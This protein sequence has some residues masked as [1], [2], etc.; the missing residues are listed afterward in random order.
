MSIR[1]GQTWYNKDLCLVFYCHA[2]DLSA[3]GFLPAGSQAQQACY[4]CVVLYQNSVYG[5][6]VCI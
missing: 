4:G 6:F 5:F 1:S 2:A 3:N